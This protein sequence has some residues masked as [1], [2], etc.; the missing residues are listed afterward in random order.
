MA[1]TDLDAVH[2]FVSNTT[3][4]IFMMKFTHKGQ[5]NGAWVF[6]LIC[7]RIQGWASDYEAGDLRRHRA[8]YDVTLM[9][10]IVLY[11]MSGVG[12]SG[13]QMI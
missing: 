10:L 13:I 12:I 6:S 3:P 7:T 9:F 1:A 11:D 8:E 4:Y 5:W 2:M